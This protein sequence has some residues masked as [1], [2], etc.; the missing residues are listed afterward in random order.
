MKIKVIAL[1]SFAHGAEM[2][3]EGRPGEF[4]KGEADDL[5]KAGLVEI[6]KGDSA[7]EDLVGKMDDAPQ[8]KMAEPVSNKA[9][10]NH[11]AK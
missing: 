7:D 5:E 1:S 4:T 2:Y 9:I 3:H 10:K 6:V 8:N 11:K